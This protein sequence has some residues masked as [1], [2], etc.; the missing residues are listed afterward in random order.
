LSFCH[1]RLLSALA[2]SLSLLAAGLSAGCG[3]DRAGGAAATASGPRLAAPT[4]Q[5]AA[6]PGSIDTDATI[7]TVLGIV[8]RA[9]PQNAGP[10]TG[11]RVSPVL[12][13]AA[14][15]A[16]NF[17]GIASEDPMSGALVTE[18][19]SPP[20]KPGERLRISVFILDRALR[21]DSLS[22]RVDREERAPAGAWHPTPI[23]KEVVADLENEILLRARHIYAER[24]RS[25]M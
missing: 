22:V 21:S 15:D 18:W 4:P 24:Y 20:G 12:W 10:Q 25:T 14:H 8:K 23:A 13:Q 6:A 11:A 19:Y 5:A 9:P 7:W 16:L 17:V 3:S 1:Y 2:A